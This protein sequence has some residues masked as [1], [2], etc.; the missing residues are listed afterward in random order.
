MIRVCI[1]TDFVRFS[2]CVSALLK[3]LKLNDLLIV[4]LLLMMMMVSET[5][6]TTLK[7][8]LK[9]CMQIEPEV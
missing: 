5:S 6:T 8:L 4:L 1:K 2:Y 9:E 7:E 3:V